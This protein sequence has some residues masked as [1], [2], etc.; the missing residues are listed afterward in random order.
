MTETV[1]ATRMAHR[2]FF[3]RT[4]AGTGDGRAPAVGDA[5]GVRGSGSADWARG[6]TSEKVGVGSRAP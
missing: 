6:D 5:V 1:V 2:G 4:G 3:L